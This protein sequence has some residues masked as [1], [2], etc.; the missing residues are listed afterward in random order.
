MKVDDI[1]KA[2][3]KKDFR[4]T[5]GTKDVMKVDDIEGTRARPRIFTRP[6]D[7]HYTAFD[8]NDV[9]K[10]TNQFTRST[11]PLMPKY[12]VRDEDGKLCEIGPIHGGSPSCMPAQPK[13]KDRSSLNVKD[14]EGA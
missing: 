3:P 13:D 8:Y 12:T 4:H 10:K 14:I 6:R 1:E 7:S 5:M 9:T 2:Q 11:N